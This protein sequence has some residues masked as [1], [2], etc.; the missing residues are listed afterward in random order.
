MKNLLLIF[1]FCIMVFWTIYT[2][3]FASQGTLQLFEYYYL[4]AV[5]HFLGGFWLVGV[6]GWAIGI[7]TISR[8]W[9]LALAVLV[10]EAFELAVFP[11][12]WYLYSRMFPY[13]LR[14][15][16]SDIIVGLVGGF[17]AFLIEKYQKRH[18]VRREELITN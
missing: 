18:R 5:M 13:W 15:T 7:K 4:D 10:W 2:R 8:L 9:I 1:I 11:D 3:F 12:V 14:D 17:V 6:L 16:S